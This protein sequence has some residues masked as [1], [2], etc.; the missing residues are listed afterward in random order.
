MRDDVDPSRGAVLVV[1]TMRG[2]AN[3]WMLEPDE[4]D[5]LAAYDDLA[6]AVDDGLRS[7]TGTESVTGRAGA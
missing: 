6:A 7:R 3:Q 2:L 4:I 1:A 5:L